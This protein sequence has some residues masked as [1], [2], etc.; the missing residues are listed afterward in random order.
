MVQEELKKFVYEDNG[1]TKVVKGFVLEEDDFTYKIKAQRDGSILTIGK[2]AI[3][4]INSLSN[5]VGK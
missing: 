2:R 1:V 5:G 3:I 4:M